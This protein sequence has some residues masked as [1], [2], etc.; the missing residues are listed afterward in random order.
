MT[1]WARTIADDPNHSTWYVERMRELAADGED[2]AGEARFVA[3]LVGLLRLG[4]LGAGVGG[5]VGHRHPAIIP[6]RPVRVGA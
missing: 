1:S 4:G 6:Q 5:L 2:L 3:A